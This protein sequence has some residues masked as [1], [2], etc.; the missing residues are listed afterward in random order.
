MTAQEL[1]AKVLELDA[2][3]KSDSTDAREDFAD[4]I[5][6]VQFIQEAAPILARIC[7]KL[8]EQRDRSIDAYYKQEVL[9]LECKTQMNA[10]LGRIAKGEE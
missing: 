8:I 5:K 4:K 6:R 3:A 9:R 1:I 10:E 2:K 7:L